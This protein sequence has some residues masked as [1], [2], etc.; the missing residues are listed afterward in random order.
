[1]VDS[2][3][4]T[5]EKFRSN[6]FTAYVLNSKRLLVFPTGGKFLTCPE[7]KVVTAST[8]HNRFLG[9]YPPNNI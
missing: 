4:L 1:M 3:L 6:F 2:F 9:F 8:F 7:E 5:L